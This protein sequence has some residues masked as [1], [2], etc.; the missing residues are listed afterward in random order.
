MLETQVKAWLASAIGI[1]SALNELKGGKRHSRGNDVEGISMTCNVGSP[2]KVFTYALVN[3]I[4][5]ADLWDGIQSVS[6]QLMQGPRRTACPFFI[7]QRWE[8]FGAEEHLGR[9][10]EAR[11]RNTGCSPSV[12]SIRLLVV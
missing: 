10:I 4:S 12:R 9:S 8:I 3:M 11:L 5:I 7:T 6:G 1:M 2:W